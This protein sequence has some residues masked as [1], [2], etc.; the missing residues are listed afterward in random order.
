MGWSY[1]GGFGHIRG[2][3][4]ETIIPFWSQILKA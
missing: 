1:K 2:V 4:L 3:K